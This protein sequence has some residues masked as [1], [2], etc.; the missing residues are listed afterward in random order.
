VRAN[1]KQLPARWSAPAWFIGRHAGG[2]RVALITD[3][4][5]VTYRELDQRVR[6]FA[7]AL[8]EAGVRPGERVVIVLP[9]SPL[10]VTAFWGTLAVGAVAVPLN[11]LL[12]EDM[13]AQILADCEPRLAIGLAGGWS[14]REAEAR[15][16]AATAPADYHLA[17]RDGF[18]FMFYSSGTTGE[19]KGVVHHVQD[20]WSAARTYG[21]SSVAC[22]RTRPA[23]QR[24]V[25]A[26]KPAS[27]SPAP[28]TIIPRSSAR[29]DTSTAPKASSTGRPW[30]PARAPATTTAQAP[31]STT[32]GRPMG[33]RCSRRA[34]MPT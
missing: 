31:T 28:I 33:N 4:E 7:A 13:L 34:A 21:H 11:P 15:L 2:D 1:D 24:A 20:M 12:G 32:D 10:H 5:T 17:H 30:G 16:A 26:K 29:V 22:E 18:A 3:D 27:A 8:A 19:P 14:A 6:R 25:Q 9:D 23:S